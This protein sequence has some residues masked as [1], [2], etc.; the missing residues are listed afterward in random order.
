MK[1]MRKDK[2]MVITGRDKGKKG[3]VVVVL[4]KTNQVVIEGI[5]VATKHIKPSANDPKGGIVK[6]T[7]PINA[8]KVMV[9]D[10]KSGRV[11]RVGYKL[12]GKGKKERI[13]KVSK[14]KNPKQS[15]KSVSSKKNEVK[16]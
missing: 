13:F 7:K 1:L 8:S 14:F 6:V 12:N 16:K 5:N 2:V 9:I 10:P 3:E 15:K 11:A 4:P